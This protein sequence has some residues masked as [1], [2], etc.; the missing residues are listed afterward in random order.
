MIGTDGGELIA[1]LRREIQSNEAYGRL[2]AIRL[3]HWPLL[4]LAGPCYGVPPLPQLWLPLLDELVAKEP[5][6]GRWAPGP[7]LSMGGLARARKLAPASC[8]F[9]TLMH[10]QI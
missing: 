7:P 1:S 5:R 4:L 8:S 3:D 6:P 10:N 2:S 9:A